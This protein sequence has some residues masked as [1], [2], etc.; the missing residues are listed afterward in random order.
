MKAKFSIDEI[1]EMAEQIERNGAK[2]YN[3]AGNMFSASSTRRKLLLYL[4][5]MEIKHEAIFASLRKEI[6]EKEKFFSILD[7]NFDPEGLSV[8]YIR[9]I[10]N[11]HV[12]KLDKP[13]QEYLTGS[14]SPKTI[15]EMA[16]EREKD[17]I[18][19][20]IGLKEVIPENLGKNDVDSIIKEEMTHITYINNELAGYSN[21][22]E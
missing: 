10:A 18:L 11:S 8:M 12:F 17:T 16:L 3:R 9:S 7:T 2:F 5:D 19:L 1:F 6:I 21:I 13:I 15:L 22:K 14:E 20:Y 4:A